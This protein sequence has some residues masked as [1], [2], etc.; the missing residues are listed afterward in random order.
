MIPLFC[1]LP[2]APACSPRLFITAIYTSGGREAFHGNNDFVELNNWVAHSA[3]PQWA[4]AATERR[5]V[6]HSLDG[7]AT[8]R[9]IAAGRLLPGRLEARGPRGGYAPSDAGSELELRAAG[10]RRPG[11][12]HPGRSRAGS[13]TAPPAWRSKGRP[14][15]PSSR[16]EACS[17]A[18]RARTPATMQT[19]CTVPTDTTRT[20]AEANRVAAPASSSPVSKSPD[21]FGGFMITS[22]FRQRGPKCRATS[23]PFARAFHSSP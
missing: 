6:D 21:D 22:V 12:D 20:T 3:Q 19:I 15:R 14:R 9:H 13:L 16:R 10:W 5:D 11:R 18:W 7:R 2:S 1:G 8:G 4:R 23:S 17:S